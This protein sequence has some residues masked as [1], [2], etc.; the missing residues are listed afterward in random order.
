MTFTVLGTPAPQ[1]SKRH[2]GH[3]I[4]VES[5]KK[6]GPWRDSVAWAA[7]AAMESDGIA[8]FTGPVE[9]TIN[10]YL[11]RG[12]TVKRRYPTTPPDLDKLMRSTCDGITSSGLWRDDS[13]VVH[14]SIRKM[15]AAAGKLPGAFIIVMEAE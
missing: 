4:M 9:L 12:K 7:R 5:S 14:S 2:V 1:G 11:S 3:G 13:Q 8:Q 10:F 15:Y 6:V